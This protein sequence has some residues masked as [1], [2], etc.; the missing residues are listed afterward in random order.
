MD[1]FT[2]ALERI[3][4]LNDS[5][6]SGFVDYDLKIEPDR[7]ILKCTVK[8]IVARENDYDFN[9]KKLL[10]SA[11]KDIKKLRSNYSVND[12]KF[13]IRK[14]QIVFINGIFEVSI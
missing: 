5:L 13:I 2:K 9:N 3:N 12:F 4:S 6:S 11:L 8:F 7:T 14:G 1:V 10:A